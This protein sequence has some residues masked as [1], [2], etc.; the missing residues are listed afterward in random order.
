[1][2]A[3]DLKLWDSSELLYRFSGRF[4]GRSARQSMMA[5][6]LIVVFSE[7]QQFFL[8]ILSGPEGHV[9]KKLPPD[10]SY[11]SFYEWM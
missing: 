4:G 2:L 5:T 3:V 1:M 8:Q 7:L 10:R 9:I 6:L 11:K